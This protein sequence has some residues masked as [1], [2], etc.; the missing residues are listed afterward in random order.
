MAN[1]NVIMIRVKADGTAE[2]ISDFD[3]VG[4]GA[5]KMSDSVKT[6]DPA[7]ALASRAVASLGGALAGLKMAE[8]AKDATMLAARVQTLAPVMTVVGNNAGYTTAQ[9][10]A[11]AQSIAE[12]G[13]TTEESRQ[14][15]VSMAAS[16]I[17]LAEATNLARIAQDAAVIGQTNSSDALG[18]MTTGIVSNQVE[19]L[20]GLGLTVDFE[21]AHRQ[22]ALSIHK[23]V[24]ELTES[25]RIQARVNAVIAK[26]KDIAGTYEA[27]MGTAGK[28]V[29]S[30]KRYHD[31]LK[32][33]IGEIFT[34]NL[35]GGVQEYTREIKG[36]TEF[37]KNNQSV[38][39]GWAKD[40]GET[41]YVMTHLSDTIIQKYRHAV[42]SVTDPRAWRAANLA[43]RDAVNSPG[44]DAKA[45][46][47]QQAAEREKI[48]KAQE[49]KMKQ[50]AE[51]QRLSSM[52]INRSRL[53]SQLQERQSKI[54]AAL[55]RETAVY[56]TQEKELELLLAQRSISEQKYYQDKTAIEKDLLQTAIASLQ[57]QKAAIQGAWAAKQGEFNDD[58]EKVKEGAEVRAKVAEIDAQISQ[59]RQ[60]MKR[61]GI[62]LLIKEI[63]LTRELALATAEAAENKAEQQAVWQQRL[64]DFQVKTGRLSEEEAIGRRYER[65]RQILAIKQE[66]LDVQILQAGSDAERL[67]LEAQYQALTQQVS[68]TLVAEEMDKA[69]AARDLASAYADIN[70]QL[71]EMVG[72]LQAAEQARQKL[73][74][75]SPAGQQLVADAMA[76]KPGAVDAFNA[77]ENMDR[78]GRQQANRQDPINGP[79]GLRNELAIGETERNDP[80]TGHK[81]RMEQEYQDRILAADNYYSTMVG[82]EQE[83]AALIEQ[84]QRDHAAKLKNVEVDRWKSAAA[85]VATYMGQM[86]SEL[87]Q[88]NKEQ[89]EIGK[90]MAQ[91]TAAIQGALAIIQAY[92]QLGPIAGTV[93]AVVIGAVTLQQIAKID[94]QEYQATRATG[95]SVE[96]GRRYLVGEHGREVFEPDQNGTMIPNNRIGGRAQ[97]VQ[98]T[99][100]FQISTGVSA[101]VRAEIMRMTPMFQQMAVSSVMQA[102]R[103]G[104]LQEA[105]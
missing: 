51:Q 58:K 19:I 97:P 76:D 65:E 26:G 103:E 36:L 40:L 69:F 52:D 53:D 6:I 79:Y 46:E 3:K 49:E 22:F 37:V 30:L 18:R 62:D 100:V 86:A 85:T 13:I 24:D 47:Q 34:D 31:E 92:G 105:M 67:E 64:D 63:D 98:V 50:E 93:A 61:A 11:Y 57:K 82:K 66:T 90:R 16:K 70:L 33:A 102:M 74:W 87:M 35:S 77:Q 94:S 32:L 21:K 43:A 95:G 14:T 54:K 48:A 89:F 68:D 1:S 17:Q 96:A 28:Q 25:E 27:A 10:N 83:H 44:E 84:I 42:L 60:E 7:A 23:S 39:K 72:N 41:A 71:L 59:K 12:M 29:G 9:M 101:T 81:M 75:E 73:F 91:A 80:Y 20:R 55:D 45:K 8:Y 56:K 4:K 2:V 5:G 78:I 15:V 88:G 38:F 104:E 99:N